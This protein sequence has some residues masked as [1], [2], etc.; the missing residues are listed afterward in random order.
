MTPSSDGIQRAPL[1][2][3]LADKLE[4]EIISEYHEGGRLPSEQQL[5]EKYAISRTI[6]REALK[7]LKERGLI[8]SRTGSGA[9]ITRPEAQNLAD[10]MARIIRV[11]DIDADSIYDVREIL[12]SAAVRRAVRRATEAELDEMATYLDRLRVRTLETDERRD[13]DFAFHLAIARASRNPLLCTLVETMSNVFKDV[14]TAGIFVQGGIDDGILRHQAIMDALRARD[15]NLAALKVHEHLY[16]S[17]QNLTAYE[18]QRHPND[19]VRREPHEITPP[20]QPRA[21]I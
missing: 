15:E 19:C 16:Y 10:V 18:A 5:A 1:Y 4:K 6:V 17:R 20:A 3:Q 2:E 11:D 7:L 13:L 12:E 14:I 9:F 8:D 21:K